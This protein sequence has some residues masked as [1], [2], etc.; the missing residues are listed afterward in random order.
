M[1]CCVMVSTNPML[2]IDQVGRRVPLV[3]KQTAWS[4]PHTTASTASHGN[5]HP[6]LWPTEKTRPAIKRGE[7]KERKEG[8]KAWEMQR[9]DSGAPGCVQKHSW[10]IAI[11]KTEG[12][13]LLIGSEGPVLISMK[14]VYTH[15]HTCTP[16]LQLRK[17]WLTQRLRVDWTY[18]FVTPGYYYWIS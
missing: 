5:R 13:I 2:S 8:R 7:Y 4:H 17:T 16:I 10:E 1:L 11:P 6:L 12:L 18:C 15:T 9:G 14:I 3:Y